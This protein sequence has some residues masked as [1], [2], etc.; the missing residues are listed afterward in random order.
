LVGEQALTVLFGNPGRTVFGAVNEMQKVFH[1]RLGHVVDS[2]I[3][4]PF[5]GSAISSFSNPGRCPGLHCSSLQAEKRTLRRRRPKSKHAARIHLK[6]W[7]N[8]V[9]S[10]G[11]AL[12]KNRLD[13]LL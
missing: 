2:P 13:T 3:V 1:Q 7:N 12:G 5:Q 11:I 10:Q 8:K 4:P 6:G 9:F